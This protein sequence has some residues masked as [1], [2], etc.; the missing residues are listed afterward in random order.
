MI[1]LLRKFS[2][3]KYIVGGRNTRLMSTHT[4]TE[5]DNLVV[6]EKLI[7]EDRGIA[8]YGLNRRRD[9]NALGFELLAA[10]REMH[11]LLRKDT[12]VSVVV[13]HSLVPGVFC[14][15]ANLKER[16]KMSDSEVASF[17]R[18]LRA[19]LTEVED[20]PMPTVAAIEG[21][22]VGG[23]LELALACDLRVA[24]AS[25]RLGL[26]ETSRGLLPGAGGT[27][28]LPRE[29]HPS[30]AK[31]LIF[32]SRIVNGNEAKQLGLV[33]HVVAQNNNSN[34]GA[35]ER[36]LVLAREIAANAPVALR[37]AKLAINEGIQVSI[38]E[39]YDVE[40][41]YYEMNIP[42][43]DRQEGMKAF[44]EKRKPVYKGQ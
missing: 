42:T 43:Q 18:T 38:K 6:F 35:F 36:A 7:G 2:L 1:M 31:E 12:G 40:Q 21:V 32:T 30:I 10:M 11:Q 15:G 20:L 14:A 37:C 27:Q 29:V 23:G 3:V 28:R 8:L 9:R 33:N 39:G 13:I 26:I 17:V 5:S 4:Q 34:N 22:A 25:A 24:A 44:F 16:F 41:K 19:T